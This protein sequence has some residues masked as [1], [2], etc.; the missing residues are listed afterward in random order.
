MRVHEL[1]KELG[2]SSKALTDLL[3]SMR[4]QVK[5][6]SSSLDDVTVERVRRHVKGQA[7]PKPVEPAR[8]AKTPS[9]ERILGLRKITP[10]PAPEPVPEVEM[11]AQAAAVPI[12]VPDRGV[13]P[14][15]PGGPEPV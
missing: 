11:P 6:H 10:P 9:G 14:A 5:S 3:A 1:A 4:V 8:V 12:E 15:K 7:E 2:L 13:A